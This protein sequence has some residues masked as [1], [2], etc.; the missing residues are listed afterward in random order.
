[1]TSHVCIN[2]INPQNSRKHMRSSTYGSPHDASIV[3]HIDLTPTQPREKSLISGVPTLISSWSEDIEQCLEPWWSPQISWLRIWRL[4]H[5]L[6]NAF[7]NCWL[8]Y[9]GLRCLCTLLCHRTLPSSL[10][11]LIYNTKLLKIG[12]DETSSIRK[13]LSWL[14]SDITMILPLYLVPSFI[15]NVICMTDNLL[16]FMLHFPRR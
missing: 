3:L 7:L 13:M 16:H 8:R 6:S 2:I 12:S 1:M 15:V 14:P 5:P 9:L 10:G 11:L 4:H